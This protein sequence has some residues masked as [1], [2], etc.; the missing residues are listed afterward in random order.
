MIDR[1]L[2]RLAE[3]Q[4]EKAAELKQL[5]QSDPEKFNAELMK[6]MQAMRGNRTRQGGNQ[7]GRGGNA[8]RGQNR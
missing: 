7:G 2:D 8:E 5:R 1:M 3:T 6:T 4:P